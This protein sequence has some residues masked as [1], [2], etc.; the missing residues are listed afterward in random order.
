MEPLKKPVKIV[1]LLTARRTWLEGSIPLGLQYG[2]RK[3]PRPR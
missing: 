1:G 2:K 3:R